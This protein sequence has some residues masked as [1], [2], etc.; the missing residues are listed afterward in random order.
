MRTSFS[1]IAAVS[2]MCVAAMALST[3]A[4]AAPA[5][6]AA[7]QFAGSSATIADQALAKVG[8]YGGQCKEFV[9][10]VVR[11]ATGGAASLGGG[12][13]SDFQ[14]EGARRVAAEDAVKGDVIQLNAAGSPDTFHRGMHTAIIVANLGN[15]TFKV[16]DSN[17]VS[18]NT[19]ATHVWNPFERAVSKGLEVNIWRF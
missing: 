1:R 4:Y 8:G 9:N 11:K 6:P 2:G 14:R 12:Y 19:V 10:G 3:N 17:F 13:Y 5:A 16:V 7:V 18:P 15:H